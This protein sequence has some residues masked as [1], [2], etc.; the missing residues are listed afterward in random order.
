MIDFSAN[1]KIIAIEKTL[2]K[3]RMLSF[4]QMELA[5]D[6]LKQ[7]DCADRLSRVMGQ[8]AAAVAC[9]M[10]AGGRPAAPVVQWMRAMDPAAVETWE[11]Q[12]ADNMH[13]RSSADRVA[14]HVAKRSEIG[15]LPEWHDAANIARIMADP[16]WACW[17]YFPEWFTRA[18]SDLTRSVI[19]A[20]WQV[21][22]HGGN[23]SIGVHRGGGKST[24]TKAL[25]ILAGLCGIVH[26]A[27][28]FG[29]SAP[30][31]KQIRR[32]IVR[33]L[34]Q[35]PR[36]LEDFPAACIP[37]RVLGGKSQ[38]A[39]GQTYQGERTYIRY[40]GDIF[41]LA[42]I[43][44]AASSGFLLKCTGVDS[45][46][47]GLIDNGVR[48]D[49]VLGDDIQSLDVAASDDMVKS[50]E[51]SVRQGFQALGG[52]D[53][54]LRIVILA[55]CTRENDFSDRVLSPEIYPEYSGLRPGLVRNWG[56][57]LDLWET[58]VELW[59]QDQR[60]GDKRFAKATA[61]YEANRAAMD[62]G[63][64][65]SD[66][67]FYVH[68]TELSAIQSAWHARITMGDNGY[69]AQIENRPVSPRTTLYDLTPVMVARSLNRLRRRECPAW[70]NG[71][72]A[73]S[74]VGYD[75]LRWGVVAFGS[76][77]RA[78]VLDYGFY[79]ER[80]I[81]VP[82]NSSPQAT[83]DFLW[84][85]MSELC[86]IWSNG[87]WMRGDTPMRIIAAG[88]DRG[89]EPGSIQ[90]FCAARA[91]SYPFPVVPLRGQGWSQW[92]PYNKNTIRA[93]WNTQMVR[94]IEGFAP[95]EF[96]NVRTDFWKETVQ[97]AFLC[98]SPDAPGACS[99]WGTDPRSHAEFGD[100]LCGEILADKGKGS[101][102]TEFWKFVMRPGSQNHL[103]DMMV[104]NYALAGFF[105]LI[106][107]DDDNPEASSGDA[108][109]AESQSRR[110]VEQQAS[111]RRRAR[112]P[113]DVY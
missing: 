74:D 89:Y 41:Q 67:D 64:E 78:A 57:G 81:V 27:V 50:L 69:F 96:I 58:Y 110:A 38:R 82:K 83:M 106:R 53:N 22:I 92:R 62:A 72:F 1:L 111:T 13:A 86:Q 7:P 79:P 63:V 73:F 60:D 108:P 70:A 88:F 8:Q 23:Q 99:L 31:A 95:G 48:P 54:P 101:A 3:G 18:P 47:L 107:P 66:P 26:Y 55:T 51:E 29:A 85:N 4:E 20:V 32:D 39:A 12:R 46:F 94:T 80:G 68:G 77:M 44:G 33:Q 40:E 49:F 28:C 36:L 45:G 84:R 11:R 5:R 87:V 113:I 105:G 109:Q 100:Q 37:L 76:R 112:V 97:R 14:A 42:Q 75:K 24:I 35:N 10:R 102:G 16:V 21:M 104:G 34:E 52:K 2:R 98:D 25:L 56:T 17:H 15:D 6:I 91:T 61:F 9:K 93:G 65:V 103:L 71:V 59:K 90:Q 19:N 30:A 43:P